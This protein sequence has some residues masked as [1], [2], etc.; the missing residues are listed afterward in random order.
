M[1]NKFK[2]LKHQDTILMSKEDDDK[3]NSI[4]QK[5]RQQL[6]KGLSDRLS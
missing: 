3:T 1:G 6:L 4:I 5:Q 2:F